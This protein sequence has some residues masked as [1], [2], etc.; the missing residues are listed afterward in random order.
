[1]TNYL[2]IDWQ[3]LLEN[4]V[5]KKG[6]REVILQAKEYGLKSGFTVPIHG[7]LGQFG[8]INFATESSQGEADHKLKKAVSIAQL[9]V[10]TIQEAIKRIRYNHLAA[11]ASQ[12]TKR[13]IECLVWATEGKSSWEISKIL[14]CS[15]HTAIFHL[16][17]ASGKLG[18][19]NRYQA[20]SKAMLSGIIQPVFS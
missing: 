5:S 8:V 9:L 13:E 12:L 3:C 15:E 17:N 2:P 16:K 7:V 6:G 10:P 18:A 1:M 19:S 14:G 11:V 20:I 4:K